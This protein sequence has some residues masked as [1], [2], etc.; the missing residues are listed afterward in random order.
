[1]ECLS[2]DVNRM[3]YGMGCSGVVGLERVMDGG[4]GVEML[5]WA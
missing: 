3:V 2:R 4:E 1:M 5:S